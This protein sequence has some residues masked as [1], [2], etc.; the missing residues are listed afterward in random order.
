MSQRR[1]VE[2]ELRVGDVAVAV[3]VE[4]AL[5]V[6][7]A[8]VVGDDRQVLAA[9]AVERGA[10]VAPGA[11]ERLGAGRSARRRLAAGHAG[12]ASAAPR[13]AAP[14]AGCAS[15]AARWRPRRRA[16][17]AGS[18]AVSARIC[19]SPTA[20][21]RSSLAVTSG[22]PALSRKTM[23][24]SRSGST[25][26]SA[27]ADSIGSRQRATRRAG[28]EHALGALLVEHVAVT[29][30][31]PRDQLVLARAR[32]CER[33]GRAGLQTAR[34]EGRALVRAAG[35]QRAERDRHDGDDEQ[36]EP[37]LAGTTT[38]HG[39]GGWQPRIEAAADHVWPRP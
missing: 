10:Q 26:A 28:R 9:E 20:P 39:V 2:V 31:G 34:G 14:R 1:R 22:L 18:E 13:R 30:G 29:R 24:S 8:H 23:P 27:A 36:G 25:P 7:D 38:G 4:R 6:A 3:G 16:C 15:S 32:P 33:V 12:A 37:A 11:G 19:V 35:E 21:S 5:E 17:R